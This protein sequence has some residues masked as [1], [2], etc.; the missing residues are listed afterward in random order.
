VRG[1]GGRIKRGSKKILPLPPGHKFANFQELCNGARKSKNKSAKCVAHH[2]HFGSEESDPIEPCGVEAPAIHHQH[3]CDSEGIGLEVVLS[4]PVV[5]GDSSVSS[6][7][8]CSVVDGRS[9]NCSGLGDLVDVPNQ[10]GPTVMVNG[11]VVA[12]DRGD[13]FHVIDIQENIGMNFRGE[14]DEDVVRGMMYESRDRHKKEDW[15]QG[16]GI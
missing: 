7:V 14:G 5:E 4:R 8:P 1:K 3:F 12:K 15:V 13:A 2:Q 6:V 9:R 16:N 11:G 10:P